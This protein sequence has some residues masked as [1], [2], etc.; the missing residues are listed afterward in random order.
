MRGLDRLDVL[1]NNAGFGVY[2]RVLQH[3]D[4]D[5]ISIT[6]VN[7][8]APLILTKRLLEKMGRGSTVVFVVTAGIHV[9][10]SELP[11]YGAVKLALHYVVEDLRAELEERGVRVLA[12]Y[13]GLVRTEFHRRAGRNVEGGVDPAKVAREVVHAISEGRKRLYVPR[14]LAMLRLLGPY[15]PL[16]KG[17]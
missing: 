9:L 5:L 10:M 7:F 1:V 3:R 11:V 17:T 8:L 15:L 2:G 4:E 12:V 14:Y 16:I 6:M 13:P